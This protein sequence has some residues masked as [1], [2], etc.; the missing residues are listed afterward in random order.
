M[1]TLRNIEK[2]LKE[3]DIKIIRLSE[4]IDWQVEDDEIELEHGLNLQIGEDYI[5][6]THEKNEETFTMLGY[7][8]KGK[9]LA[10]YLHILLKKYAYLNSLEEVVV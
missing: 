1:Y 4:S 7:Y 3:N 9:S 6:I 5:G 8:K 2:F 10:V